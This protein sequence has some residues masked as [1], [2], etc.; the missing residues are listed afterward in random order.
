VYERAADLIEALAPEILERDNQLLLVQWAALLPQDLV[1]QRPYLCAYLGWAHV[2]TAQMETASQ[3]LDRAE[4]ICSQLEPRHAQIIQGHV[5][6]HRAYIV[7]L[8]GKYPQTIDLAQSALELLP[9]GKTTLR[10]RALTYLGNAYNYAGRLQEAKDAFRKAIKIA[11][12][13]GSL[14]LAMFSYCGLGE[15]LRD[16][17]RLARA[18][19]VYQ[20]LIQFAQELVGKPEL[21]LTGFAIFEL[22]VI[23]REQNELDQAIEQIKKGVDLCRE[24]QQ[25]EAL[26]IGL[27]ELAETHRR[28]GE[29]DQA[30]AAL[31]EAQQI[32]AAISP[33]AVNF[34][35]G[36]AA[37]LALSRG[38]I[39]AAARW[40]ER[41][42]LDA[43]GCEIGYERFPECPPLIRTCIA[44]GNPQRALALTERLIQ[45]DQAC[46]RLGRVLD[47]LVLKV[48]AL[49]ALGQP[50][51]AL[52][53][54]A[55]AVELA[56]PEKHVRPFL[57]DGAKLVPYLQKLP[58]APHRDRLLAALGQAVEVAPATAL[59]EPLNDREIS[60]LR[61]M[62]A[63]RSN[64]EIG[65]ELYLS[66]NTIRWYAS[67]IYLKLGVKN[68]GEAVAQA[69]ELGLLP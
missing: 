54:L 22:G 48:A 35:Q 13:T 45:R 40:A 61:L 6:V 47:L 69:R 17:G 32:A 8:Q 58:P 44:T 53:T 65:D 23:L 5:A 46:G 12:K 27:I 9:S 63:G 60:I 67:Q 39:D 2:L 4:S 10:A 50:R 7:F 1:N 14:S 51:Q 41:S 49:D 38:D 16:E 28:R 30:E 34:A 52:Q 59:V 36:F 33:W 55:E 29:Y 20:Q 66:V 3:W 57:D 62:S 43:Q 24:W 18:A 25:G 37:R 15:V 11:K 31:K 21:P 19:E 26:G 56:A 64:R 68:R 42:D